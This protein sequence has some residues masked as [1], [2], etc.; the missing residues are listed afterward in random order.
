MNN[1]LIIRTF[2]KDDYLGRL[3]CESFYKAGMNF[4]TVYIGEDYH[5][6]YLNAPFIK[7]NGFGNFGGTL[8]VYGIS[9]IF[10]LVDV[11]NEDYVYLSDADIVIRNK[12]E[13]PEGTEHAGT[14]GM[15]KDMLHISGQLQIL[16]GNVYNHIKSLSRQEIDDITHEMLR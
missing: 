3:C 11:D 5:Y 6:Q 2:D 4:E 1:K 10:N 12:I 15:Y 7:R 16:K 14:G 13:L 9:E 8:G